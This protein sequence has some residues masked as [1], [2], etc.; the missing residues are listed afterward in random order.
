M[1]IVRSVALAVCVFTLAACGQSIGGVG[2]SAP[3]AAG[4]KPEAASE[5]APAV[6]QTGALP[7]SCD[8]PAVGMAIGTDVNAEIQASSAP[9]PANARY[10]CILVSQGTPQLTLELSGMTTDLDLYVGHGSIRSVQGVDITAG[11]TYEW[12]SN[13]FGTVDERVVIS[14]PQPGI[15]YA[16]IVSYQAQHSPF[17]FS[18]R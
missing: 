1:S 18:V 3:D 13:E 4:G 8:A 5:G 12:K 16:E 15:Y 11:Q 2:A 6:A 10:Y 7:E 14:N 9:Y 17:R